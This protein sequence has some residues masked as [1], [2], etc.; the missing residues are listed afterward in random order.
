MSSRAMLSEHELVHLSAALALKRGLDPAQVEAAVCELLDLR[1]LFRRVY[2]SI[3]VLP[4][5]TDLQGELDRF[6]G[7]FGLIPLG[8]ATIH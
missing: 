7:H 4:N 2:Y 3:P 6:A 1:S 8:K 5:A